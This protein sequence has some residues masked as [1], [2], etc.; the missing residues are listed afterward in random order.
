MSNEPIVGTLDE[1]FVTG[2]R[3]SRRRKPRGSWKKNPVIVPRFLSRA[4]TKGL[5]LADSIG[6]EAA[7]D[8]SWLT[9]TFKKFPKQEK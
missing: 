8:K 9:I 2:E 1:R 3:P 5:R 6:I 7:D 4:I